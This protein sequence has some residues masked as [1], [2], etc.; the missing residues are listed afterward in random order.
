M[1]AKALPLGAAAVTLGALCA[2]WWTTR[3]GKHLHRRAIARAVGGIALFALAAMF[4]IVLSDGTSNLR[5]EDGEFSLE[6]GARSA[7][8]VLLNDARPIAL[9][10]AAVFGVGLIASGAHALRLERARR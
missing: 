10:V 9:I 4:V 7:T 2:W 8:F 6:G 3:R 1:T 5:M